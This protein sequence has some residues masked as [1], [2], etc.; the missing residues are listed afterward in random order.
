MN[1]EFAGIAGDIDGAMSTSIELQTI[2]PVSNTRQVSVYA[3]SITDAG[4]SGDDKFFDIVLCVSTCDKENMA[5]YRTFKIVKRISLNK[6]TLADQ[7]TQNTG[8]TVLEAS[9]G[10]FLNDPKTLARFKQLAGV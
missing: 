9:A 3:E 4:E 2:E 10:G 7:A 5:D 6:C 8:V 1:I